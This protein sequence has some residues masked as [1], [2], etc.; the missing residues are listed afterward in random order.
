MRKYKTRGPKKGICNICGEYGKLTEDHTSPKE[1]A[2]ITQVEMHHIVGILSAEKP[3]SRV[4]VS[5]NGVKFRSLCNRCNNSLLG[6][7]YRVYR[8]G[9]CHRIY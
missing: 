1:S 8:M 4:R 3:G 6:G 7:A 2:T 9:V 5:Q